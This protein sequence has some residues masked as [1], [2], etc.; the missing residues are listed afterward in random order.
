MLKKENRLLEINR[1]INVSLKPPRHII[2]LEVH[3][4]G[5]SKRVIADD[6]LE[7]T[8]QYEKRNGRLNVKQYN[9]LGLVDFSSEKFQWGSN[10]HSS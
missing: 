3:T 9:N 2:S 8:I 6:Y 10:I 4:N 7:T 1:Q 5:N